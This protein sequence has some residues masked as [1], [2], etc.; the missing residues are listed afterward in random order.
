MGTTLPESRNDRAK[1]RTLFRAGLTRP[2]DVIAELTNLIDAPKVNELSLKPF[3]EE[4]PATIPTA[5]WQLNHRVHFD[6]IFPQ[7][8]IGDRYQCDFLYFTKSSAEWWCVLVEIESPSAQL[9]QRSTKSIKRSAYLNR[10]L[11]QIQDWK[12]Y[13][14]NHKRDFLDGLADIRIPSHM[15]RNPVS[16]KYL[17][18]IGRSSDF[19]G[20]T[21]K[22]E[23][24]ASL[25]ESADC[26][27]MTYDA[28][29]SDLEYTYSVPT[30]D[31]K[32]RPLHDLNLLVR[33]GTRFRVK[34][35]VPT[36]S[37]MWTY[38]TPAQLEIEESQL[39][40]A[41][42]AGVL[43]G[44]WAAGKE[45]SDFG[46]RCSDTRPRAKPAPGKVIVG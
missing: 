22:A 20:N 43:V 39:N 7:Y 46:R 18:V 32:E 31:G 3:F 21:A 13:L 34:R 5:A 2:R 41:R 17:L 33:S 27:V 16:F 29:V 26:R 8:Q 44:K 24:Y 1:R 37:Q 36:P 38:F 11:D 10:A 23:R 14:G 45:L 4:Y 30:R 9:F 35:L 40:R 42:R 28:V 19:E 25:N 12:T 6:F 15:A